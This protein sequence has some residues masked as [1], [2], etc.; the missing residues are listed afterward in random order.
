MNDMNQ[1]SVKSL[2]LFSALE[3][4]MEVRFFFLAAIFILWVDNVFISLHQPGIIELIN[5]SD[6]QKINLSLY[7]LLIFVAFSFVS[8][9]VLPFLSYFINEIYLGFL[10][11]RIEKFF[12]FGSRSSETPSDYVSAYKLREIAHM[13]KD[14]FLLDVYNSY[15]KTKSERESFIGKLA[16][17][18]LYCLILLSINY[19]KYGSQKSISVFILNYLGSSESIWFCI[20]GLLL[21]VFFRFHI[22]DRDHVYCPSLYRELEEKKRQSM[23]PSAPTEWRNT[24]F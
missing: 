23:T 17:L 18:A 3:T 21:L 1:T 10:W 7:L 5:A 16:S 11:G 2:G 13:T 19:F 15:E 12:S 20:I 8:S 22:D 4:A 24:R 6:L 9:I 14:K